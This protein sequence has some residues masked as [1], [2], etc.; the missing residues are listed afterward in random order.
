MTVFCF[1]QTSPHRS[2]QFHVPC[3]DA[4]A[5]AFIP[6]NN[7][8]LSKCKC[9]SG[10]RIKSGQYKDT[11]LSSPRDTCISCVSSVECGD[12]PTASPTLFPTKSSMPSNLPSISPKPSQVPSESVIPSYYPTTGQPTTNPSFS[13]IPTTSPSSNPTLPH[14]VFDGGRCRYNS[15]C[16]SDSCSA[17][18][19]IPRYVSTNCFQNDEQSLII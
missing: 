13:I 19:C 8:F 16:M 15:E 5:E 10:F 9:M 4:Y 1:V 11:I 12:P 3:D 18:E 14:S 2:F 7:A 17:S 6:Y